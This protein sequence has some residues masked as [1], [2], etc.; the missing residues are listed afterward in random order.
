MRMY[1]DHDVRTIVENFIAI[2]FKFGGV[3]LN[4][5]AE[6]ELKEACRGLG[7]EVKNLVRQ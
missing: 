2:H 4:E 7:I 6:E 5:D 1:D 3:Y